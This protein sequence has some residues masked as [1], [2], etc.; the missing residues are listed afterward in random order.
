[1]I[2]LLD[3]NACIELLRPNRGHSIRQRIRPLALNEVAVCTPVKYELHFGAL[4]SRD[5]AASL[6]HVNSLI[7]QFVLLPFDAPASEHA[8]NSRAVLAA[9][10][11]QIGPID[12][13]IA[14]TAL[15]NGA[16]LVTHNT[17]EFSRVPGLKVEDWQ[18]PG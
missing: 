17:K 8:A 16:T 14:G 15:A 13:L 11:I 4:R 9:A 10:G 1:L 12:L 6:A 2:Y 18:V 7:S 3:T 5:P